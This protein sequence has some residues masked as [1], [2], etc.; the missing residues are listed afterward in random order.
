MSLVSILLIGFAMSADAF[1]AAIGKGA[2]MRRPHLAQA[3]RAGAIFGVIEGVTPVIGWALGMAAAAYIT[4]WDHWIAFVLLALLGGRMIH[5]GLRQDGRVS[6]DAAS[7]GFWSLAVTGFATSI[8]AMAIGVGMAF[9]DV[10]IVLVA[11]VIGSCTLVMVTVGIMLGRVLGAVAGRRA[12][13]VGGAILI[14]VGSSI[15]YGHL[16]GTAGVGPA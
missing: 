6:P 15:L 8:D 7:H 5:T 9:I 16:A 11:C 3:L 1:A 2:A 4:R 10:S 12:E 13:V 14:L